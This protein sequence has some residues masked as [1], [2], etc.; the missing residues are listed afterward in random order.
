MQVNLF[1]KIKLLIIKTFI[2][3]NAKNK[4]FLFSF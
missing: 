2:N 4:D 1:K 3:K